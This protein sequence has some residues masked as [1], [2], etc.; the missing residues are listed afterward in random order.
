MDDEPKLKVETL[1]E[2]TRIKPKEVVLVLLAFAF[3]ALTIAF[4]PDFAFVLRSSWI[5]FLF[6]GVVLAIPQA[7]S[8]VF[9]SAVS[10]RKTILRSF[11]KADEFIDSKS[12]AAEEILSAKEDPETEQHSQRLN[13]L[14]ENVPIEIRD[15]LQKKGYHVL[16]VQSVVDMKDSLKAEQPKGYRR[17]STYDD[18]PACT[19]TGEKLIAISELHKSDL[20][21][22]HSLEHE[23]GHAVDFALGRVSATAEFIQGYEQ[24]VAELDQISKH[25]LTYYLQS[26]VTGPSETFAEIFNSVSVP[27]WDAERFEQYFPRCTVMVKSALANANLPFIENKSL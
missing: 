13:A 5:L 26:G 25:R 15:F 10:L 7:R 18:V 17:G 8:I 23:F 22:A 11:K 3:L 27:G 21:L 20:E 9:N 12:L 16:A 14:L 24:D 1:S 4:L 6:F 19:F 2:Y